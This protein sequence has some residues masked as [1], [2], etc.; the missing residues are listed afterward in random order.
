MLILTLVG[1]IYEFLNHQ[2]IFETIGPFLGCNLHATELT[3]S[4][5][6]FSTCFEPS[7]W[8][9]STRIPLRVA[10]KLKPPNLKGY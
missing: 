7:V 4:K 5:I 2:K 10:E 3:T 8:L 9:V 1:I 6:D